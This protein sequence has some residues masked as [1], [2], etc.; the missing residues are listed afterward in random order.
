MATTAIVLAGG[1]G[2]RLRRSENKV[3]LPVANRPLVSWS[4]STFESSDLVDDVLLV[5]RATDRDRAEALLAQRRLSKLRGVV[6]GGATRHASEHAGLTAITGDI[7]AGRTDLVLIHDAARPF[8][9]REL[10]ARVVTTAKEVGGAIPGLRMDG[11]VYRAE[12]DGA[13]RPVP[14]EALRRVQ[15]PQAFEAQALL[16][17]YRAAALDDFH[18]VDTAQSVER[19]TDLRV[20]VVEG[21]PRNVKVTFVEDLFTV[22]SLAPRWETLSPE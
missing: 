20:A 12:S 13:A 8:V 18:G 3:Y 10:L 19:Y 1:A 15:T 22:E 9:S 6:D 17:A 16:A 11:P 4:L 21:D 14:G 7:E 2:T 5:I